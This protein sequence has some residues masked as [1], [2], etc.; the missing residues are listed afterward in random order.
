[1]SSAGGATVNGEDPMTEISGKVFSGMEVASDYL[2]MEE[3]RERIEDA[4]G[5]TPYPGTLNLK[6]SDNLR[7]VFSDKEGERFSGFEKDGERYSG[8]TAYRINLQGIEA[9]YLEIDVT[10][11]ED[12][13]AEIVA[14]VKLRDRL[15]LEDGQ[16]V[17]FTVK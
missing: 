2:D 4:S 12:D 14:P 15:D 13:V 11:Y 3:Y 1:M 7:E 17:T 16:K 10:D 8:F 5:F 9:F 6:C